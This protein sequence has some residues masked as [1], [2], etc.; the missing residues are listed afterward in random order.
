MCAHHAH[1]QPIRVSA[2]NCARCLTV[3]LDV[4]VCIYVSVCVYIH[5]CVYVCVC[6][7]V[8]VCCVC[9]CVYVYA[10]ACVCMCE[11]S[12]LNEMMGPSEAAAQPSSS[13]HSLLHQS[14]L[15]AHPHQRLP[16]TPPA[17]PA[18]QPLLH[19]VTPSSHPQH[20]QHTQYTQYTQH[21]HLH[22]TP[23]MLQHGAQQ[24]Q[25]PLLHG[26]T[27]SAHLPHPHHPHPHLTPGLPQ[28]GV[29]QAQSSQLRDLAVHSA[30]THLAQQEQILSQQGLMVAQQGQMMTQQ[31]QITT[32]IPVGVTPGKPPAF[33]MGLL[34]PPSGE[35]S[36]HT[37]PSTLPAIPALFTPEQPP[38]A[39]HSAHS[40]AGIS[41][42][43]VLAPGVG[44]VRDV[45]VI[46]MCNRAHSC[47][48]HDSFVCV[49]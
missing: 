34:F 32:S 8:C 27:P 18:Q 36:A 33:E 43:Q 16:Y 38:A 2:T 48:G 47:V 9:V 39:A 40:A 4:C 31:G 5:V 1:R 19:S 22:L 11:N 25:Q 44:M 28:D 23:N 29:Q 49:T 30:H 35:G 14:G 24:A 17:T 46:L 3:Y 37:T 45:A 13:A 21:T 42:G 10:C 7:C 15:Q 12:L 20:T 41:N 26:V 6:V